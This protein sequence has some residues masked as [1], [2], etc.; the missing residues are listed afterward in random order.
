GERH[1]PDADRHADGADDAKRLAGG[2]RPDSS[3]AEAFDADGER[4]ILAEVRAVSPPRDRGDDLVHG[5]TGP[6]RQ[7]SVD[8][9]EPLSSGQRAADARRLAGS[10]RLAARAR[11]FERGARKLV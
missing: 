6:K 2:I 1:P 3:D 11:R 7:G 10:W 5:R 9:R 4:E 8:Q